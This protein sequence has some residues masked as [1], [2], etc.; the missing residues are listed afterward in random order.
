MSSIM[1]STQGDS[2]NDIVTA[3]PV[4]APVSSRKMQIL[5]TIRPKGCDINA[6]LGRLF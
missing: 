3:G 1:P 2:G 4:A 5:G 6:Y